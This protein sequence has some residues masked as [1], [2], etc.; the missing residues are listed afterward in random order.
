MELEEVEGIT[1]LETDDCFLPGG[2]ASGISAATALGLTGVVEGADS[3]NFH[4]KELLDRVFDLDFVGATIDLECVGVLVLL[5]KGSLLR[6]ADGIDD[7][8][9]ISHGLLRFRRCAW[10]GFQGRHRR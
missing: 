3:K 7:C 2:G 9:N 10:R 4:F 6:H 5:K 8:V 1:I